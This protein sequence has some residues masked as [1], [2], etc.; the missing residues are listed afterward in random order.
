MIGPGHVSLGSMKTICFT[1][2][3]ATTSGCVLNSVPERPD[4]WR[5]GGA[6]V[7]LHMHIWMRKAAIDR[8]VRVMDAAGVGVGVNLSGGRVYRNGDAP[9]EFARNLDIA[10]RLH[11]GRFVHYMNL[12]WPGKDGPWSWEDADKVRRQTVWEIEEGH[13]LGAAGL[14]ISKS[15]GLYLRDRSGRLIP[16]DTPLL[17]S[18]W[19]RCGELGMPVS[20]H[21]A[22]PKAF[23]A[24]FEATNER[25]T[26]LRDHKNWWFGDPKRYPSREAILAARN[27]VIERHPGTT[28]V[29]VHFGNNPEDLAAVD[30]WLDR[31]PNMM[32]DLAARVPEIGRH[33]PAAVRRFF[34]KHQDRILFAT[35][36]QSYGKFTL[37]S[38]GDAERPTTADAV[39]FYRKHWRFL[40]TDDRGFAHM[41]PIQGDWTIDAIDL[42]ARVLRKIYFE[43]ARKLLAGRLTPPPARAM[44]VATDFDLREDHAAWGSAPPIELNRQS[45]GGELMPAMTTDVRILWSERF[46]YL[47]YDCPCTELTVFE[48]EPGAGRER[49]GLWDR[50]V[51]EAFVGPDLA[52]RN[53]YKEF[54][55]APDG[56][57][58]DLDIALPNKSLAWNSGFD[59]RVVRE[60][61]HWV[62]MMRIP[63]LA[64]AAA[65]PR[66]GDRW[67]LN[68]Y[69]CDRANRAF[70]A[71]RPT[72]VSTFHQPERFGVLQFVEAPGVGSTDR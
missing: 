37:G 39:T 62:G 65:P 57:H 71:Y 15:L 25:W 67:R 46:L 31:Y 12:R 66:V 69:R 22:D 5:T 33:D 35:D 38:G 19:Q 21:V 54:E 20:I 53:R 36:F 6:V 50:D 24:P 43:N 3:L 14:K 60:R 34:V 51:V 7:D 8:A 45:L 23:W 72:L 28:F 58:L 55:L 1:I 11:P 30:R 27:R 16:V 52:Q 17:D 64:I 18:M 44:R 40:E 42:P 59:V 70:L 2:L 41:T 56:E 26:E 49:E 4:S 10:N 61:G 29:C 63:L 48:G 68:L 47:R 32:V 9:S 13:R